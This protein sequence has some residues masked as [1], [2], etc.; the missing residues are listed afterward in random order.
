MKLLTL[1][2]CLLFSFSVYTQKVTEVKHVAYTVSDTEE[3][4]SFLQKNVNAKVNFTKQ[5]S[6]AE[7]QRLFGILD[8]GLSLK[9]TSMHIGNNNPLSL[10]S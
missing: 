9:V 7:L 4:I 5:I 3:A 2:G 8:S 1:I 10:H 6:G